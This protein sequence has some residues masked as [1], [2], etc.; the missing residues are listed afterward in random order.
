MFIKQRGEKS[1]LK[2]NKKIHKKQKVDTIMTETP[3]KPTENDDILEVLDKIQAYLIWAQ[4]QIKNDVEVE[5]AGLDYSIE[6][7]CKIVRESDQ[8]IKDQ[9]EPKIGL[10]VEELEKLAQA[11]RDHPMTQENTQEDKNAG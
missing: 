1:R 7:A 2:T 6:E 9:A 5:L 10:I 11:L 4:E 3:P 8:A